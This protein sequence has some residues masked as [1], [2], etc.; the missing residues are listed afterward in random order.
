MTPPPS[1]LERLSEQLCRGGSSKVGEEE[2]D[3]ELSGLTTST[4]GE[5]SGRGELYFL[6]SH[7]EITPR[8]WRSLPHAFDLG[9]TLHD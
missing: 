2:N 1:F 3:M 4:S 7:K 5:E 8:V 9:R 6:P